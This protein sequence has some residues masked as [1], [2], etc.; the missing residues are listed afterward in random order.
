[1]RQEHTNSQL[2]R[3]HCIMGLERKN[4]GRRVACVNLYSIYWLSFAQH[5]YYCP[6]AHSRL[7][8]Y[9]PTSM[10]TI[11]MRQRPQCKSRRQLE[12]PKGRCLLVHVY[13]NNEMALLEDS[14]NAP[15]VAHTDSVDKEDFS[16]DSQVNIGV[17]LA[18]DG[19]NPSLV[20]S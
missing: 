10:S 2:P 11:F 3:S 8:Y 9:T 13:S 16:E 18:R 1:M 6:S 4:V 12:K 7:L 15:V 17:V 14:D 5:R 19:C 20:L